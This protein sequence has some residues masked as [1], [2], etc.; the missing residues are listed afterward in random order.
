[1]KGDQTRLEP[2]KCKNCGA[3]LISPTPGMFKCEHCGSVFRDPQISCAIPQLV[4]VYP[5]EC[6]TIAAE[7]I[8][9]DWERRS[10]PET[11]LTNVTLFRLREQL[12]EGLAGLLRVETYN[13][14]CQR[15]TIVRGTVRVIP[16][17]HRY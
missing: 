10:I 15:A 9:P 16:P 6:A 12:A 13:D 2:L 8:I 17:D 14:P 4:A 11:G 5:P 1:M 3:P 7:V